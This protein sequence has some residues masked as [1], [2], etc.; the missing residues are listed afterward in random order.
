MRSATSESDASRLIEIVPPW[1]DRSGPGT[2]FSPP[3]SLL[4][5]VAAAASRRANAN[6]NS[7]PASGKEN[8]RAGAHANSATRKEN[9]GDIRH[10]NKHGHQ[11]TQSAKDMPTQSKLP[12]L[13]QPFKR[14]LLLHHEVQH[15]NV[16]NGLD[17]ARKAP[18]FNGGTSATA[19]PNMLSPSSGP[20]ASR[21]PAN[22]SVTTS[23]GVTA[24][25]SL[26]TTT[27]NRASVLTS[28][29][30]AS[31]ENSVPGSRTGSG[32]RVPVRKPVPA[33]FAAAH[34][35][36]KLKDNP[37]N[38][39]YEDVSTEKDE[40]ERRRKSRVFVDLTKTKANGT[41]KTEGTIPVLDGSGGKMPLTP[42]MESTSSLPLLSL[43]HTIELTFPLAESP[44]LFPNDTFPR[45]PKESTGIG[46]LKQSIKQS[47][48]ESVQSYACHVRLIDHVPDKGVRMYK[49]SALGSYS[50][51]LSKQSTGGLSSVAPECS[52][53][54]ENERSSEDT[55]ESWEND[56]AV[57]NGT[58][59]SLNILR[60]SRLIRP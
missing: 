11:R 7:K 14:R 39:V 35:G 57:R 60:E 13:V 49:S 8:V 4:K 56:A 34:K 30:M 48:G 20:L 26:V 50:N 6:A 38:T 31:K 53:S 59:H 47:L 25:T 27:S 52:R 28:S 10:E 9:G 23:P 45:C 15:V 21:H 44:R 54:R 43:M 33:I 16:L 36:K 29:S 37:E 2:G 51:L 17:G 40:K 41:P 42:V 46:A 32:R 22:G 24:N 1:A 18:S 19:S 5:T 58:T 3:P 55:K 12:S